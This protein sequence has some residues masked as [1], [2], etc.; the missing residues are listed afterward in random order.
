MPGANNI[1]RITTAGAITEFPIPTP[2]S[3]PQGITLGPDG[4]L[5]FTE[6]ASN[7][8]K[9]GRIT[10]AGAI[11]EFPIPTPGSGPPGITSGPDGALW[12]TELIGNKIGRIT[13][14]GVITEFPIPT[15]QSNS[16][17]ITAGPDGALWFTESQTNKIGR[18]TTAGV[19]TEFPIPT[20]NSGPS[21]ITA[22]PDGA[23]WFTE[24]T[25][26][27]NANKI[28]RITTA[29][30]VTNEFPTPTVGSGPQG[31]TLGPDGAL[32]FT[33]SNGNKIGRITTAGVITEF[34]NPN[35]SSPQDI[36]TG[37]DGALW[38]TNGGYIGRLVPPTLQVTPATNMVASGPQ[39]GPFTP[40]SFSYT[41]SASSGSVNFSITSV[42]S[43][44]TPSA[45]SGVASAAGTPISFAVNVSANSLAA[46]T[47]G[48]TTITFTNS[49]SGQGTT[50]VTATLT[51]NPPPP[52]LQVTPATNI[53]ASG[54]QGG[55]FSPPSISYVLSATGGSVNFSISGVPT[56]LTAS[57]TSGT[58]SSGTTVTFTVNSNA[59]SLTAGTFGPERIADAVNVVE[60]HQPVLSQEQRSRSCGRSAGRKRFL[61]WIKQKATE[62]LARQS[63]GERRGFAR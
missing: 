2:S 36:T 7:A 34:L 56:W 28:G 29:G 41:L 21:G 10:T 14:A 42:P 31:I 24:G 44:L 63:R 51:V 3:G 40:P 45:T 15:P 35:G 20:A 60:W 37:P 49:D 18:I 27:N 53:V 23:L 13:T 61:L 8:N 26:A 48:P 55:P 38:F 32:W 59:S 58:A 12:F 30:V 4:A 46:G 52:V 43:W 22:G 6:A 17:A 54:P 39:G 25:N 11:T 57:A 9:I 16:T 62:S 33:E 47:Y 19:I 50:T 5:W 1:G